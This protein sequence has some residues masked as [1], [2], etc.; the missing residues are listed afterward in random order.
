MNYAITLRSGLRLEGDDERYPV[1]VLLEELT[2]P[3]SGPDMEPPLPKGWVWL[4][5]HYL[6]ASEVVAIE[7]VEAP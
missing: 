5:G 2:D 1:A 3:E 7:L 4:A 6:L